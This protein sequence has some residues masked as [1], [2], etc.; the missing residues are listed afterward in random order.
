[1][2][3]DPAIVLTAAGAAVGGTAVASVAQLFKAVLPTNWQTGRAIIAIVYLLAALLVIGAIV[4]APPMEGGPVMAA[5][6]GV[7]AWQA[8]ATA[9]IG[10]NQLARKAQDIA[11][12]TTNPTGPDISGP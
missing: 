9:A 3:F 4:V 6:A 7:L 10:T 11:G 5:L 2:E 12:G 8:V 1:M